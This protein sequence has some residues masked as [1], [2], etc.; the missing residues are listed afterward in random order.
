[1]I[2]IVLLLLK[3]KNPLLSENWDILWEHNSAPFLPE[4]EPC[5]GDFIISHT[6]KISEDL[7][8]MST[9]SFGHAGSEQLTF[10][11]GNCLL[12]YKQNTTVSM[13]SSCLPVKNK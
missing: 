8:Q 7:L 2:E 5:P 6:N 13:I 11:V 1:M 4:D 3:K 9:Q 12:H 10:N